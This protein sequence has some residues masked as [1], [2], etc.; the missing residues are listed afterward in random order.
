MPKAK[1]EFA[2]KISQQ[3][4][5]NLKRDPFTNFLVEIH[6]TM[7]QHLNKS[8]GLD[9]FLSTHMPGAQGRRSEHLA[10][11]AAPGSG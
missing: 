8:Y 10:V 6:I 7:H 5:S 4:N 3:V 1:R 11:F 9:N 2:N